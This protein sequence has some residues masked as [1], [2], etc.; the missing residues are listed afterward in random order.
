MADVRGLFVLWPAIVMN[1]VVSE[2]TPASADNIPCPMDIKLSERKTT[3]LAVL[4]TM[5]AKSAETAKQKR[6]L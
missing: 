5:S 6:I 4:K 2:L 3:D 1:P